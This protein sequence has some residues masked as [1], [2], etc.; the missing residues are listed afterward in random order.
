MTRP[1]RWTNLAENPLGMREKIARVIRGT[2]YSVPPA[3]AWTPP[4]GGSRPGT[5]LSDVALAEIADRRLTAAALSADDMAPETVILAFPHTA[6]EK[7]A[8]A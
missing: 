8:A 3:R 5:G 2:A 7:K 1:L 4:T 6:A